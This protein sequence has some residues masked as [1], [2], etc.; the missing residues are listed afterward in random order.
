L[1]AFFGRDT[2]ANG[3]GATADRR[4]GPERGETDPEH[5]GRRLDR[6]GRPGGRHRVTVGPRPWSRRW[7]GSCF[8]TGAPARAFHRWPVLVISLLRRGP[9]FAARLWLLR[10]VPLARGGRPDPHRRRRCRPGP[11]PP[12]SA[13]QAAIEPLTGNV[14]DGQGSRPP[15]SIRYA[16]VP[17][18]TA[19]AGWS[20]R[21]PVAQITARYC[22][23]C[24]C[25]EPR[26]LPA[27]PAA[28]LHAY[29]SKPPTW[30]TNLPP[31]AQA[32]FHFFHEVSPAGQPLQAGQLAAVRTP[33]R[34]DASPC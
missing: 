30:H 8:R 32:Y 26:T 17:L 16:Y 25:R 4:P 12:A 15:A 31:A 22:V 6:S 5:P 14:W 2:R 29:Q 13:Q 21:V 23:A 20:R 24:R 34:R 11:R 27:V 28:G 10:R 9:L 33:A 3:D 18:R 7:Q 1:E 19:L